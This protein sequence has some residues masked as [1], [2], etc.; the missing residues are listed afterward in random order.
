MELAASC[1]DVASV[2]PFAPRSARALF[3]SPVSWFGERSASV[4]QLAI[5]ALGV[6]SAAAAASPTAPTLNCVQAPTPSPPTST[7]S[8]R[9][10][11]GKQDRERDQFEES[12]KFFLANWRDDWLR[13]VLGGSVSAARTSEHAAAISIREQANEHGG[14]GGVHLRE[15]VNLIYGQSGYLAYRRELRLPAEFSL[16]L[17]ET[18]QGPRLLCGERP[19]PSR[20]GFQGTNEFGKF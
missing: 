16:T 7:S 12:L 10:P 3:S 17:P 11:T 20:R 5:G 15:C 13:K 8:S 9:K 6:V 1:V 14:R 18:T 2:T 19:H 4:T